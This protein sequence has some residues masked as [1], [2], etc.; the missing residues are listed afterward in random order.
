MCCSTT[1]R[2]LMQTPWPSACAAFWRS[3]ASATWWEDGSAPS[4]LPIDRLVLRPTV[5]PLDGLLTSVNLTPVSPAYSQHR[6]GFLHHRFV[7]TR[8]YRLSDFNEHQQRLEPFEEYW[9]GTSCQQGAGSDHPEQ[10]HR[11]LRRLAQRRVDVLLSTSIDEDQ[12][13]ARIRRL[14]GAAARS[15]WSGD[16]DRVSCSATWSR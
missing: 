7:G 9:A 6:D 14:N 11:A 10:L 16:G 5:L 15:H 3:A 12:R 8:P 13:H 2:G 1:E 4:R